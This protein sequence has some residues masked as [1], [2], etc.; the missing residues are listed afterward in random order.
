MKKF[1]ICLLV[2]AV[3]VLFVPASYASA[4]VE[5]CVTLA[6]FCDHLQLVKYHVGG[7]AGN[8]TVGQWDYVCVGAGAGT[9]ISGNWAAGKKTLATQPGTCDAP[10]AG[11]GTVQGWNAT[12]T[13]N[14]AT[15]T[16]DLYYT[17][18][19]LTIGFFQLAKGYT[20]SAG[21]CSPLAPS[22]GPRATE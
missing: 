7:V 9:L 1:A 21:A 17:V 20:E 10:G 11:C 6:N 15:G 16:F 13:L 3:A 19:G 12:W 14:H 5:T 18:D 8:Q 2:L 22:H 4:P